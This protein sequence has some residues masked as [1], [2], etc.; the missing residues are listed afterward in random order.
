MVFLNFIVMLSQAFLENLSNLLELKIEH[1]HSVSG[2]DISSAYLIETSSEKYFLKV[3]SD[4][5]A[6][7]MFKSEAKALKLIAKTNTIATP[8]VYACDSFRNDSF[9]LMEYIEPKRASSEDL[10]LFGQQLAQ[11]HQVT[12]DE[13]GFESNN[14]IGSLHQSNNKHKLWIDFYIEERLI[15]QLHLAK[16]KGLLNDSEFPEMGK[17]KEDCSIYFKDVNPSL[18]HGDLWSGNYLISESGKPYLIDS[19]TY[20]GHSEVDIAMSKL[21]GGFGQSFYDS[22]HKIIPKDNFTDSRIELYQLYYLL[23]HLNIFGSSYYFSVKGL[24]KKYF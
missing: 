19:A 11:L 4:I 23:V 5:D 3:N 18:L 9:L 2:G 17:M 7:E 8:K 14:F 1:I 16:S 6:G 20:F 21:F 10:K 12:S 24:L 15:P 13:F 22:Y